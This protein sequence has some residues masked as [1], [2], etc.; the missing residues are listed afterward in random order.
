ME[1]DPLEVMVIE[2]ARAAFNKRG[3]VALSL[4]E[5]AALIGGG[6]VEAVRSVMN[7]R[8]L[9]MPPS[10]RQPKGCFDLTFAGQAVAARSYVGDVVAAGQ[11]VT[12]ENL[13][14]AIA[15]HKEPEL[16]EPVPW[17][18]IDPYEI[19]A[20]ENSGASVFRLPGDPNL[21][22]R[23]VE[24]IPDGWSWVSG[25]LQAPTEFIEAGHASAQGGY[26]IT[27][28][29]KN[30][31]EIVSRFDEQYGQV[32]LEER[33]ELHNAGKQDL[34]ELVA[35]HLLPSFVRF[36]EAGFS[37]MSFGWAKSVAIA[38]LSRG[39]SGRL[40]FFSGCYDNRPCG[41]EEVEMRF[42]P[43]VENDWGKKTP[44]PPIIEILWKPM[45]GGK[46]E[47]VKSLIDTCETSGLEPVP[48]E[49]KR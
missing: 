13:L 26:C 35:M 45:H 27:R 7:E 46:R 3:G 41:P 38:Y 47:S 22:V 17:T 42:S 29:G 30:S 21:W 44:R 2:V 28:F 24:S 19:I 23:L 5:A 18:N 10:A 49:L 11:D 15:G 20:P 32:G 4:D 37:G 16:T 48:F 25:N 12:P 34:L 39:Y 36:Q 40:T 33:E 43:W 8:K 14:R 9:L 31:F 6:D 1:I